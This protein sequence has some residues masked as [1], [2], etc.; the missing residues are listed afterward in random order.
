MK[1]YPYFVML[2]I[3]AFSVFSTAVRYPINSQSQVR[4][5]SFVLST[6]QYEDITP[7]TWIHPDCK[8]A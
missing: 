4:G 7:D 8:V 6:E 1:G 3:T 2:K 5:K